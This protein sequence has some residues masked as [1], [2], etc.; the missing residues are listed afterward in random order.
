MENKNDLEYAELED[1]DTSKVEDANLS[2]RVESRLPDFSFEDCMT[3]LNHAPY[4]VMIGARFSGKSHG[5]PELVFH[6]DK[7]FKYKNCFCI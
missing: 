4:I 5:I 2:S 1:T 3:N 6:L 7:K